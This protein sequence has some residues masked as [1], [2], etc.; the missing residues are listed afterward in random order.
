MR[1]AREPAPETS[2]GTLRPATSADN[3]ALLT[4]FGDVP[5]SGRLVLSTRRDPNFFALY[6]MQ[7]G[8]ADCRVYERNG[9][10]LSLGTVLVRDGWIDGR[11]ARV[12]YL[13]D[14]RSR[15]GASREHLI[16]S[17]YAEVLADAMRRHGCERFY[18]AVLASNALAI[19]SLVRRSTA[20]SNQPRY[21]LLR[22]FTTTSV[23]FTGPLRSRPHPYRVRVATAADLP[24]IVALLDR[25]HRARPFGY[26]YDTG[27]LEHRLA[28]WPGMSLQRT[29][30]AH[31]A[32][33]RLVGVTTAWDPRAVKRYRVVAYRGS[34]RWSKLAFNAAARVLRWPPLP[35]PGHDF[36]SLY[37]CNTSI[38]GDRAEVLRAL[39]ERIYEDFR[40]SGYHFFS[41]CV[42]ENDPLAPALHGLTAQ[43]LD[44]H[45]Y[46]VT[47]PDVETPAL[48]T[49]RPGFEMALA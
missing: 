15:L 21:H 3:A 14:L 6:D 37:L 11:P 8:L 1:R 13:G 4:L 18:T 7:R 27:E 42:Y 12:G 24:A 19:N 29:Y 23:Q 32:D 35:E 38:E 46:E 39:I 5:M 36:R 45:L 25:D 33:G 17:A 10:L 9:V 34:M 30:V 2:P 31:D 22:R 48:G 47:P 43:R 49:G 26:R 28:H 20:R 41:L 44:F 40:G 16:A